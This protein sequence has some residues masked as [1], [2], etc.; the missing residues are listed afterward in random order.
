MDRCRYRV[1]HVN[2]IPAIKLEPVCEV[3]DPVQ[4]DPL[5]VVQLQNTSLISP[6][7]SK[8]S[9]MQL[10]CLLLLLKGCNKLLHKLPYGTARMKQ[11]KADIPITEEIYFIH[12]QQTTWKLV[13]KWLQE[14][15]GKLPYVE[16]LMMPSKFKPEFHTS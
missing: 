13:S 1:K 14:I 6:I 16:K 4:G 5:K 2:P 8:F 11:S 7:W 15:N 3:Y 9:I 10:S 12:E